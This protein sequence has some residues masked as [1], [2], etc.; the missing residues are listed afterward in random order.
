M[1]LKIGWLKDINHAWEVVPGN[2]LFSERSTKSFPDD[3]HLTP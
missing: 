1:K 2:L 3:T